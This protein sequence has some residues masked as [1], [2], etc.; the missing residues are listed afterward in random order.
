MVKMTKKFFRERLQDNIKE[1]YKLL[2]VVLKRYGKPQK[3]SPR[4]AYYTIRLDEDIE[5]YTRGTTWYIRGFELSPSGKVYILTYWQ[6]DSTDGDI[7]I[8]LPSDTIS[9]AYLEPPAPVK[10]GNYYY[11]AHHGILIAPKE[12]YE[13]IK[14]IKL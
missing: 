2:P 10:M 1:A 6:G 12:I 4:K 7:Y 14:S 3:V 8:E 9:S 11:S 13:A 5:G